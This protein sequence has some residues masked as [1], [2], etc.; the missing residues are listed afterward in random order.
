MRHSEDCVGPVRD[1]PQNSHKRSAENA[2]QDG[3]VEFARHQNQRES[4]AKAGSLHFLVGEAAKANKCIWIGHDK[5]GVPQSHKRDEHSNASSGGML[6]AIG[7]TV[8]DLLA[9]A[10]DRE[11][12]EQNAGTKDHRECRAPWAHAS[13]CKPN[14]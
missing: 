4:E 1:S 14:T 11:Y 10:R 9:N 6:Q 5:L 8:H 3:A 7:H 2:D 12:Q 13:R